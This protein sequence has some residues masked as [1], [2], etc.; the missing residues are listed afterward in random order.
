MFITQNLVCLVLNVCTSQYSLSKN[1]YNF[2]FIMYYVFL[3]RITIEHK[4]KDF[5]SISVSFLQ[6]RKK[7]LLSNFTQLL[8]SKIVVTHKYV[9]HFFLLHR[10]FS[11]DFILFSV[12]LQ[13]IVTWCGFILV[14]Y[15]NTHLSRLPM[16]F[17][18]FMFSGFMFIL[19]VVV[20]FC[21]GLHLL[22]SN[23]AGQVTHNQHPLIHYQYHQFYRINC[24]PLALIQTHLFHFLLIFAF[25]SRVQKSITQMCD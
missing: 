17:I 2:V 19:V 10:S 9:G 5:L 4:K 11:C 8:L 12:F 1:D 7:V 3:L 21:F 14:A 18:S 6:E 23:L 13:A 20:L 24:F 25:G 22:K 15:T 16:S